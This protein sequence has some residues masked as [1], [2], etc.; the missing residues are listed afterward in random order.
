MLLLFSASRSVWLLVRFE[1]GT[2]D[3]FFKG[4][5]KISVNHST[6]LFSLLS[7]TYYIT[8]S[9]GRWARGWGGHIRRPAKEE[10]AYT[11]W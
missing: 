7:V 11:C 5:S 10:Y 4:I 8:G 1:A 3:F 9:M 6:D 2:Q